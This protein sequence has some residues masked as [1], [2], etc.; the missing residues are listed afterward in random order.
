MTEVQKR[1][2]R[3]V[4]LIYGVA[5]TISAFFGVV[6]ENLIRLPAWQ[7][8]LT[9]GLP[10]GAC[11]HLV[12]ISGLR[13][14]RF[15]SYFGTLLVRSL[16]MLSGAMV[17][18]A[19]AISL[20]VALLV[21]AAPW[22]PAVRRIVGPTLFSPVVLGTVAFS[23]GVAL[24]LNLGFAVGR[25]LG[26]GVAW[27]WIRGY[28]HQP[29]EED[30]IFL[31]LDLRG[32]TTLAESMGDLAYSAMI[33]DCF[34][35]LT[36]PALENRAQ[37]SHYV[38]DE[39]VITWPTAEGLVDARCLRLYFDFRDRLRER[40]DHYEKAY[41]VVPTFKAGVHLGRVITTEVGELKS[42]FVF[43][44]DVVNITSRIQ[45]LC[46][47]LGAEL[48]ASEA[49]VQQLDPC[50][51]FTFLDEGLHELRGKRNDLRIYSVRRVK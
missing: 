36:D 25:K 30:R 13:R 11:M 1:Q 10:T 31:F 29:R 49:L 17:G 33:R 22:D 37:I 39:A 28:Y 2:L 41:G 45:G 47:A 38:G 4:A 20:N 8:T 42:E 50:P 26:P 14:R 15:R 40:N 21:Q 27:N 23:L 51:G 34:A 46:N 9:Y 6:L 5:L 48:L 7:S 16:V 12:Q 19:L 32:S 3:E 18:F 44:G 24:V 35:D 43:H